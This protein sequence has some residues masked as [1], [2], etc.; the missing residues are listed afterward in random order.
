MLEPVEVSP[1]LRAR[2]WPVPDLVDLLLGLAARN[3]AV[4]IGQSL[5]SETR[6]WPGIAGR[7]RRRSQRL[8][9]R[10]L[11]RL[12]GLERLLTLEGLRGLRVLGRR[13]LCLC[14]LCLRLMSLRLISLR[15]I[16]L[17]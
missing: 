12:P 3:P 17:R 9:R 11:E 10:R 8:N 4:T 16:S 13:L 15:L 6:L 14:L 2:L 5:P 1:E 7:L